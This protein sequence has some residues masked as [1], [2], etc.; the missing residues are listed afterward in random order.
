MS[1]TLASVGISSR[2]LKF[3]LLLQ[4]RVKGATKLGLHAKP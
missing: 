3:L 1:S 4:H 2:H